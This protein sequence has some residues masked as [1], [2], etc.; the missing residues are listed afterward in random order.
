MAHEI[1]TVHGKHSMA[2]FG[3]V[4]WH[5]LGTK[6]DQPAT[7]SEAISA[8]GLDYE[9]NLQSL[10][11]SAGDPVPNRQAVVRQDTSELLGVV[12]KGYQP[13]QNHECFSFLDSVVADGGL[14]YHTAGALGRGERVWM[15]AKLPGQ[16]QVAGSED[17][18]E[19]F[20]LL[21]NSHDG[22]SALRVYFTPIRVVC[23][24]T[25]AMAERRSRKEGISII[26]KG[27]LATKVSEA[28]EI[29]GFANRFY[30]DLDGKINRLAS[31]HP[32]REQLQEYFESLYPDRRE[33]PSARTRNIR[34]TLLQLFESGRG[35]EI[36]ASRR[37][38]WSAYNA[39]TEY[40]D[41][42]RS[43]RGTSEN[44]RS[45]RRLD[46]AWFGSGARLKA[47]AWREAL[48]LLN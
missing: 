40:I 2:Y 31:Y 4:P 34:S 23:A 25:L 30:D 47:I 43:T 9:V 44:Q 21:S 5:Q 26:H 32:S 41:H 37:S 17:T 29:L 28:Q 18:T 24:N 6:L 42:H 39:I 27:D 14:R 10:W 13:I 38:M 33:T 1:A 20:L 35:Q 22:T 45:E 15:L 36:A 48:A 46:S 8:A 3:D 11:T 19:K 16:I 7:A 12:G